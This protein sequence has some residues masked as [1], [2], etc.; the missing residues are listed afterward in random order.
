MRS[1]L[2]WQRSSDPEFCQVL[3]HHTYKDIVGSCTLASV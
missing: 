2:D 1:G 3:I